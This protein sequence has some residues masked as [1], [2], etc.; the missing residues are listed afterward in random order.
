MKCWFLWII[1]D[2]SLCGYVRII[3][4]LVTSNIFQSDGEV[5]SVV[6][7][8]VVVD[9]GAVVV[10]GVVADVGILVKAFD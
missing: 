4:V 6:V 9:V 2:G 5:G 8:A 7:A 10:S 1:G 3:Q